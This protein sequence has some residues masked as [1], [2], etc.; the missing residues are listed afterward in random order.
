MHVRRKMS[1]DSG[2]LGMGGVEHCEGYEVVFNELEAYVLT[3]PSVHQHLV[4]EVI[5]ELRQ[6]LNQLV[7]KPKGA[8]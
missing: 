4:D 7:P 8:R 3:G 6:Q 1:S 5:N 2:G